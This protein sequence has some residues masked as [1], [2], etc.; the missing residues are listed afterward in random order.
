MRNLCS[1]EKTVSAEIAKRAVFPDSHAGA[2]AVVSVD[3]CDEHRGVVGAFDELRRVQR[4]L[5]LEV[6]GISKSRDDRLEGKLSPPNPSPS[7]PFWS[8]SCGGWQT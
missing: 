2:G 8:F 3:G 4:D 6:E 7:A 5:A 1:R